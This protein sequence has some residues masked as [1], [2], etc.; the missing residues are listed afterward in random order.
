MAGSITDTSAAHAIN[1]TTA[2][3]NASHQTHTIAGH[4]TEAIQGI[5]LIEALGAI[6]LLSG[7]HLSIGAVDNLNL[8]TSRNQHTTAGNSITERIGHTRDSLA[9]ILQR[10]QVKDGGK[11]WLGNESHKVLRLLSDLMGVVERVVG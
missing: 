5:K 9:V 10:V 8:T 1:T 6:K 7:G 3:T 4:S 11:I 2:T